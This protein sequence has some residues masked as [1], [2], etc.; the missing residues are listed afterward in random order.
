MKQFGAV[1]KTLAAWIMLFALLSFILPCFQITTPVKTT[2]ISGYEMI[3]IGAGVGYEYYSKGSVNSDYELKDGLTWGALKSSVNYAVENNALRKAELA[4]VV[5]VFPVIFC[6]L[7][8]ILTF[9]AIGKKTML[10]PTFLIALAFLENVLIILGFG[11]LEKLFLSYAEGSGVSLL[12]MIGIYAFTLL[13][14]IAFAIILLLWF[15]GGFNRPERR[16]RGDYDNDDSDKKDRKDRSSKRDRTHRKKR[17]KRRKSGRKKQK[18]GKNSKDEQRN[19]Q[20]S[21]TQDEDSS[22]HEAAGHLSGVTGMYQGIDIDLVKREGSMFTIGT[23]PEAM[24]RILS[25]NTEGMEGASCEISY[26]STVKEYTVTSHSE[27]NIILY[28]RGGRQKCISLTNGSSVTTGVNTVIYIGDSS[29]AVKL[30]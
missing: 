24:N 5:C 8:M 17:R 26:D 11:T 16:E 21:E 1:G 10:L 30:D 27:K 7:A 28:E 19:S 9:M 18:K 15:M 12:L 29:N 2:S 6:F 3:K 25:G 22:I 23:T 14:G 20:N 13:C 4:G